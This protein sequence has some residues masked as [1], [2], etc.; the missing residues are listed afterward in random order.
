[1]LA[2]TLAAVTSVTT[3]VAPARLP[4]EAVSSERNP[5]FV[6]VTDARDRTPVGCRLH[7]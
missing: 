2:A 7:R 5:P 4:P 1:M 6:T 3:P